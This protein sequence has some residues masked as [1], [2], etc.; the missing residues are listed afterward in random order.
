VAHKATHSPLN[1]QI[2]KQRGFPATE[3]VVRDRHRNRYVDAHHTDFDIELKLAGSAS[4]EGEDRG[5][6]GIRI[7]VDEEQSFAIRI[8]DQ[9][10][11]VS[12]GREPVQI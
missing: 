11:S 5:S 7:L 4:V 3:T 1:V 2:A 6:V 12:H 8:R 9:A 10:L